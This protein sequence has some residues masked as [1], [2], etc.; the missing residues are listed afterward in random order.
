[1]TKSIE[2]RQADLGLRTSPGSSSCSSPAAS[3]SPS[4]R[5]T[6]RRKV[7]VE[8]MRNIHKPLLRQ[9][10]WNPKLL[11]LEVL[12]LERDYM[13]RIC[14]SGYKDS[15]TMFYPCVEWYP[16]APNRKQITKNALQQSFYNSIQLFGEFMNEWILIEAAK[17]NFN[18]E[19]RELGTLSKTF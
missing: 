3:G 13:K 19:S 6:S 11:H 5:K 8:V 15:L 18:W 17:N 1:M 4:W 12:N 7:V 9:N 2:H 16:S 14:K 10:R